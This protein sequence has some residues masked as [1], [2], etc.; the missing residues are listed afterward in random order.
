MTL[1]DLVRR[2]RVL[3]ADTE[4]PYFW[5][6]E[7]L[8]D[9]FAEAEQQACVR[10]RLLREDERPDVCQV[11]LTP[12]QHT[13]KLHRSV[14]ELIRVWM[15]SGAGVSRPLTLTSRERLDW[16]RPDWRDASRMPAGY[17]IQDD[18]TVRVAGRIGPGDVLHLECYRLPLRPLADGAD[19]PEI[20]EAHH[21]YLVQWALFRAF[22]VPDAEV[23]DPSRSAQ[24]LAEF[25]KY[26]GIR[27]DSDLRRITREDVVHHNYPVLP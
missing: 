5:S 25:E 26:F 8:A 3:A 22:S 27:V 19:R 18:T 13:Y 16:D 10:A 23:F 12:G 21:L 11:K 17:V 14:Y 9:W 1:E 4:E 2:F 7:V 15:V 24:A 6:D 20:H